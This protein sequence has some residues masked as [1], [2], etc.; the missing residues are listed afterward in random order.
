MAYNAE[1]KKVEF[2][3]GDKIDVK[4]DWD[5]YMAGESPSQK[6]EKIIKLL[7]FGGILGSILLIIIICL[8]VR[9][10][11]R[12]K[13]DSDIIQGNSMIKNEENH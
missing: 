6:K 8:V 5:T 10:Y 3:G 4:K 11:K 13:M 2:F 12:R 7:I 1:D 9:S